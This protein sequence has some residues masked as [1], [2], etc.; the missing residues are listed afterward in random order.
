MIRPE[1][2]STM[3]WW[4]ADFER[5]TGQAI[6]TRHVVG[7]MER[8]GVGV[9]NFSFRGIGL[10]SMPS[11]LKSAVRLGWSVLNGRVKTLYLVCS[12]S[13]A[14]FLRDVPAYLVRFFGVRV[15]VHAHGSDIVDLCRRPGLGPLAKAMLSRCEVIVPS[16]HLIKSLHAE[17]IAIVHLCENFAQNAHDCR[18]TSAKSAPRQDLHAW[19]VLWNSNLMAS[20]GFFAVAQAVGT[21]AR[22]GQSIRLIA[23]GEPLGDEVMCM[24]ACRNAVG[25]LK[26]QDWVELKGLVDRKT[27]LALLSDADLVC[28][29]SHYSSECQPLALIEAMCVAR[30]V[31]I[32]DTPAL[33]ATVGDYPCTAV[34]TP[35]P[36]EILLALQ[37]IMT[38]SYSRDDLIDASR[39]ARARFSIQR[40][41]SEMSSLLGIGP[42]PDSR[43]TSS[44]ITT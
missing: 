11:A 32:A 10:H 13:N 25:Q 22:Q 12:R 34:E 29:P 19:T 20:K 31:L 5:T 15:L 24:A 40:F 28:L 37:R 2:K 27:A 17:G 9:R 30:R 4:G 35:T 23:L 44:E 41:E 42:P 38:H 1:V 16:S 26:N 18:D 8:D 36:E 39:K 7:L 21:L 3:G 33:R 14:G 43:S 6:I